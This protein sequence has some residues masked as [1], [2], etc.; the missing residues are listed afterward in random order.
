MRFSRE[1][2]AAFARLSGNDNPLH[3]DRQA[4]QRA[5]HGEIIASGEQITA[6]MIGLA[7]THFSRP[8]GDRPR[9]LLC[10]NFNFAFKAP[11]FAE[12]TIELAWRV[13]STE[14][15]AALGGLLVQIDGKAA[16]RGAAP[17]VVARGTLLV[18]L[19][20]R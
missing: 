17:A 6:Q 1:D 5:R 14:P 7:S 16:V 11:V 19:A 18:K 2:I 4:A 3:H 13:V 12:Q 8:D 15:H 9:E 10:L 20:P